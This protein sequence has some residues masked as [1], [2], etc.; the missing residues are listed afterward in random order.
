MAVAAGTAEYELAMNTIR[1]DE[2]PQSTLV[3]ARA[4]VHTSGVYRFNRSHVD[5]NDMRRIAYTGTLGCAHAGLRCNRIRR[6]ANFGCTIPRWPPV[7]LHVC[8]LRH[9]A[10]LVV[11]ANQWRAHGR[12][13][14]RRL[15]CQSTIGSTQSEDGLGTP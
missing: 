13:T 9:G 8:S 4:P 11:R 5:G 14:A 1:T 12:N 7:W 3:F 2:L 10:A 15:G 6:V